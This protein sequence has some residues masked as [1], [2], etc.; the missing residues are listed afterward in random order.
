MSKLILLFII[1]NFGF[2]N[3]SAVAQNPH[4]LVNSGDRQ[5]VLDKI[6][7]YSWAKSIFEKIEK[8]VNPYVERHQTNPQ[9]ILGRY[10]MNRV[11]GKRYTTV[12]SDPSGSGL[13]KW[14]GDAPVPTV[15]VNTYLRSPIT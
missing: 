2:I 8:E 9:W 4:I 14:S 15:R 3:G 11:P 7:N 10:L 13:V 6:T 5:A 12:F 1:L